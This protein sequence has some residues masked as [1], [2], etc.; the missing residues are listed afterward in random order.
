[1]KTR[2]ENEMFQLILDYAKLDDRIRLVVI[3]GSRV[4]LNIKKDPFQDYDIVN[5]VTD[6]EPYKI[7]NNV[8]P[9]FGEMLVVEQP[10]FGP[11]P[12][13][14]ADGSFHNYNMQML[15]GNR[16]DL[17]FYHIDTINEKINDS[18]TKVLL[19][20]D[21]LCPNISPPNESDY[22]IKEPTN[23]LYQGC[24]TGFFFA[25]GSH[26]PKTIWRRN[27]PYLKFII[28]ACLRESVQMMLAWE[29]GIKTGFD[30]SIGKKGIYLENYLEPNIWKDYKNTYVDA[31]YEN[32]WDSLFLFYK[33]FIRS[34]EFVAKKY[35]YK[36][37][38][39]KGENVLAF[40]T[41]VKSLAV[42]AKSIY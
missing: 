34:A 27:L 28:Q 25:L 32:I 5:F 17:S 4:N 8:V 14:N 23:E 42:N 12:P 11:W 29:I 41:H 19:D 40:L 37:P 24:C 33:I 22:F 3:N 16:I 9:H 21:N 6:V 30:K 39:T 7:Q 26:I 10:N 36:F 20:K 35:G 1:M 15:D 38:K 18:L 2:N 31:N 13:H